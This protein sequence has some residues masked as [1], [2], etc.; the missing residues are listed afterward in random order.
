M[1]K[2]RQ[3]ATASYVLLVVCVVLW[4]VLPAAVH[5]FTQEAFAE[6]Q[7]PALHLAGKGRDLARY[8]EL[9]SR[10]KEEIIAASRD[11]AR[12]NAALELQLR[13]YDDVRKEN[14][15]LRE[16]LRYNPP[17]DFLT[18]VAR[19]AVRD[20]TTWWQRIVIRK[21]SDD[22][23]RA[24]CPVIFSDRV[25]GKVAVAHHTTSEVD[26]ITSPSFRCTAFLEGDEAN[27][28]VLVTG[29]PGRGLAAGR[30]KV[31]AIPQDYF[32]PVGSAPKVVTTGL[33][34]IYPA[35]LVLGNLDGAERTSQDG[36]FKEA[37]LSPTR[38]L[39]SLQEVTVL[40]PKYPSAGELLLEDQARKRLD[41]LR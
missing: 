33:G 32:H 26:L 21:G 12:A 4:M 34:G 9:K 28:I 17:G 29:S 2:N 3:G 14:L 25:V 1:D 30:A 16:M 20:S 22:G 19:V 18:V 24:G 39:F 41:E 31:S 7:A 10:D 6:F 40:V 8:W 35:G 13:R 38:D 11:L 5:R 23:V 37:G 15:R 27:R 36:N